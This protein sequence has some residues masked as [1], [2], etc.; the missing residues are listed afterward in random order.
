MGCHAIQG[1]HFPIMMMRHFHAVLHLFCVLIAATGFAAAPAGTDFTYFR[2][3]GGVAGAATG[4]LPD[5]LDAPGVLRWMTPVDPGQSTP[6]LSGGK[7]FLTAFNPEAKELVTLALDANT[8]RVLWKTPAPVARIETYHGKTG[9]PVPATPACDGGRL[10]VFF[11]SCG[12][13][14]YNLDG[15]K[16]WEHPMGPF[17]D[18][19]GAGSSQC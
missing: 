13:I 15:E 16:I 19:Y 18:E 2:S 6:V 14:C 10:Y 8:G 3:D 9:S 1:N 11:G 17:Q 5:D 4:P 7:V 12:L